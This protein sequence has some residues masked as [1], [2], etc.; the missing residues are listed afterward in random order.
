[1]RT[2]LAVTRNLALV[3]MAAALLATPAEADATSECVPSPNGQCLCCGPGCCEVICPG[4]SCN[5][6][7]VMCEGD[8]CY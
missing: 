5:C 2:W 1:M 4:G 6:C 8:Y 3:A 7:G